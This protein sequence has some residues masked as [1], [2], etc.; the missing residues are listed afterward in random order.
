MAYELKPGTGTIWK[1]PKYEPG[2]NH[3]YATGRLKDL[4]G[5]DLNVALWIPKN[6]NIK[7]FNITIQ[8][9]TS[10]DPGEPQ[11]LNGSTDL[12]F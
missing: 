3:P 12:P 6:P 10:K 2:G 5:K 7:A 8:V 11:N 9:P 1:N 4:S